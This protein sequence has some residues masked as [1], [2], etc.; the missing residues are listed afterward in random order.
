M[1]LVYIIWF[2]HFLSS[3]R[4]EKKKNKIFV[5]AFQAIYTPVFR[6][7]IGAYVGTVM[8]N[9]VRSQSLNAT[10]LVWEMRLRNV[11]LTGETAYTRPRI[12]VMPCFIIIWFTDPPG[13]CF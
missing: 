7:H 3:L 1:H 8:E 12:Q 9:T 4:I 10:C 5:I 6:Q 2:H 11:V 13:T